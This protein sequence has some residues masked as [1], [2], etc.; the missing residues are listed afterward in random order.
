MVSP[1]SVAFSH[2]S[3]GTRPSSASSTSGAIGRISRAAKVR[4]SS[5]SS[6]WSSERSRLIGL[7]G[8]TYRTFGLDVGVARRLGW[9]ARAPYACSVATSL[10]TGQTAFDGAQR[11]YERARPT[12]AIEA[13]LTSLLLAGCH[14]IGDVADLAA[15]TGKLTRVLQP[16]AHSIIAIEPS[17]SMRAAFAQAVE[18]VE[19][20]DGRAESI[21]LDD[22]SVD[23]VTVG[24][25]FHWF[26][27]APA[28]AEIARVLRPGGALVVANNEWRTDAAPWL[29][30][31]LQERAPAPPAC[32]RRAGTGA[33]RSR[34][35]CSSRRP[36]RRRSRTTSCSRTTRSSTSR[37]RSR[38]STCWPRPSAM[39]YLASLR[40]IVDEH[41]PGPLVVPFRT[42]A[43]AAR[44]RG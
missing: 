14:G 4:A 25:A 11:A 37:G 39:R 8:K 5:C 19:V 27:P 15:G 12:Y 23:L 10:P 28:L 21:P 34:A 20:R 43:V 29:V 36:A 26:R 22:A 38:A 35:P 9:R 31:G 7:I 18:G 24:A 1:T 42:R 33:A 3:H 30:R 17:P 44:R 2:S 40:A 32:G 16:H 41:A 6:R 13:V